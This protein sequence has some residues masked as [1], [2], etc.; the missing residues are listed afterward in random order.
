VWDLVEKEKDEGLTPEEKSEL[1]DFERLE[2]LLI[3]VKAKARMPHAHDGT[4]LWMGPGTE[5]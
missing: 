1:D 5:R 4:P 3:P 2:H